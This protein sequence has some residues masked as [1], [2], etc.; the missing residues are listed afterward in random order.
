MINPAA[1]TIEDTTI[2]G[3]PVL[4]VEAAPHV[5]I[6]NLDLDPG[7]SGVEN[8]LYRMKHVRFCPGDAGE[9]LA[10]L[11]EELAAVYR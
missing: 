2:Y 10:G 5:F 9:T 8:S 3:M 11:L 4:N 6:Y 1:N 7:Y